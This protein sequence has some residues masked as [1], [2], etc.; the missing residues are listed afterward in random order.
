MDKMALWEPLSSAKIVVTSLLDQRMDAGPKEEE[1][2]VGPV[3]SP[4]LHA[5]G[6]GPCHDGQVQGCARPDA[7]AAAQA[8]V[9]SAFSEPA[10]A[11]DVQRGNVT[12]RCACLRRVLGHAA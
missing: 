2:R 3:L 1:P 8:D 11:E 7:Q 6:Q 9:A 5:R 12:G 10:N 4:W